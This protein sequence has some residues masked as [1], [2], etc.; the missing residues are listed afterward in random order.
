MTR[1][2]ILMINTDKRTK[3]ECWTRAMGYV[4]PTSF[5][6]IGK[7]SEFKERKC[8]TENAAVRHEIDK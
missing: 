3:C 1:D 7:K 8:F 4:R 6:N 2:E 5:F